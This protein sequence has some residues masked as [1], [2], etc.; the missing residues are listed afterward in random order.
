MAHPKLMGQR[1]TTLAPRDANHVATM[2]VIAGE[3]LFPSQKIKLSD[4]KPNHVETAYD[5]DA[6]G[7][8][9]PFL[10]G[11]VEKGTMFLM[12]LFPDSIQNLRHDWDHPK[13]PHPGVKVVEKIV[14][15]V[16]EVEV[17]YEDDGCRGCY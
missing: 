11:A 12:F 10:S 8:V 4:D 15:K 17:P 13:I 7:I 14:E 6:V 5:Q 16:V 9:D 2:R 1:H 3:K